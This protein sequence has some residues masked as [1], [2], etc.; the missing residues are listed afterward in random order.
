MKE[1]TLKKLNDLYPFIEYRV[2]PQDAGTI[3][4][5]LERNPNENGYGKMI[6]ANLKP[7]ENNL[8]ENNH[9]KYNKDKPK[10]SAR[11]HLEEVIG[12][13]KKLAA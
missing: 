2:L 9:Y 13:L 11:E 10:N 7:L 5:I 12:L 3:K 6:I 4:T 8:M 1:D